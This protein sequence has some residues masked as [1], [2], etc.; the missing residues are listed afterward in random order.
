MPHAAT[1]SREDAPADLA[2]SQLFQSKG[3]RCEL[4]ARPVGAF[5]QPVAICRSGAA[6]A[7]HLPE[8]AAPYATAAEA[9]RH[10][11]RQAMRYAS[12]H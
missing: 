5:F 7:V 10:A 1:F 4:V 11:R 8:D 2:Q 6:E 3:W 12:H 9:L